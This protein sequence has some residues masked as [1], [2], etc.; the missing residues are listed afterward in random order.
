MD[1]GK[2]IH[3]SVVYK[4]HVLVL[5]VSTHLERKDEEKSSSQRGPGKSITILWSE[6][7][8]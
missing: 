8:D 7:V 1:K 3:L 2:Q 5:K 6:G 4:K